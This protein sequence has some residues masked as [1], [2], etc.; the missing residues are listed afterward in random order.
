[1]SAAATFRRS[2]SRPCSVARSS[3]RMM[4]QAAVISYALW[5]RRFGGSGTVVGTPLIIERVPFTIIGVTP[6]SFFGTEV[7]RAADIML[8]L[9][10]EPLIRGKDSRIGPDRGFY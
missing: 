7:G 2:A 3:R 8:P 5:Q 6:P 4:C 1:M 9:N 10:T